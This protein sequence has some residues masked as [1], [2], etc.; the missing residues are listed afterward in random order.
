MIISL[1]TSNHH[2]STF[3][4][5][6]L[7]ASHLHQVFG[8]PTYIPFGNLGQHNTMRFTSPTYLAIFLPLTL[9]FQV[10]SPPLPHS[11]LIL[12][13]YIFA[14]SQKCKPISLYHMYQLPSASTQNHKTKDYPFPES[15]CTLEYTQHIHTG[16]YTTIYVHIRAIPIDFYIVRRHLKHIFLLRW[17]YG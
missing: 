3:V 10:Q 13:L 16:A 1:E 14:F 7:C 12:L 2:S 15:V 9:H 8:I 4:L 17:C 6:A 5:K 11:H